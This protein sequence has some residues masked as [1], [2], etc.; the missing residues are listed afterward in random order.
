MS[1]W[2]PVFTEYG[3]TFGNVHV[4]AEEVLGSARASTFHSKRMSGILDLPNGNR[5]IDWENA[6]H[7]IRSCWKRGIDSHRCC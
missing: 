6:F 4:A 3:R 2:R 1:Q 5:K 7:Y